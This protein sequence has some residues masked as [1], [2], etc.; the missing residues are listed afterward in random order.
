MEQK[1]W[2]ISGCICVYIINIY[3]KHI[4]HPL[5]PYTIGF[6]KDSGSFP[7]G[8]LV[9]IYYYFE[10]HYTQVITLDNENLRMPRWIR[11]TF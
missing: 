9:P 3:S 7:L 4:C 6:K 2:L 11:E 1:E 8:Y 10:T 5:P